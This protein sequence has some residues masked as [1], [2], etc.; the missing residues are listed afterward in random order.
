MK[1]T[2]TLI[3]TLA[4]SPLIFAADFTAVYQLAKEN[5]AAFAE[6]RAKFEAAQEKIPQGRAGLLPTISLSGN[7]TYNR[8]E[9]DNRTR[10]TQNDWSFNSNGLTLSLTQP[11]FRWQ[12]WVGYDQSKLVVAQAEAGLA[13]ARQDLILRTAQAYFDVLQSDENYAAAQAYQSAVAGQ[14]DIAKK[15]FEIGTGIQTDVHD[16]QTRYE[17]ASSQVIAAETEREVKRRALETIVGSLPPS[18]AG[19]RKGVELQPPQPAELAKWVESAEQNNLSVQQQRLAVEIASREVERQRAGHYPTLD[20]VA[21]AGH[22]STLSSGDRQITDASRIG[23]QLNVPIF[24]GGE[25]S[26][27]T[28]EAD[29]NRRA[30]ISAQETARRGAVLQARQSYLGVVNGLAQVKT[31]QA[32]NVAAQKAMTSNKDAFDV[33]VR[34]GIDVLNAQNQ[35]YVTRRDLTRTAVEMLI[36]QLRL[37]AAVGTLGEEDVQAV[38]GLLEK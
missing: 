4:L 25:V 16:A 27:K 18:L 6:A 21:S 37:K 15:A 19:V 2:L 12:N 3:S 35:V 34:L 8:E 17:I 29:A 32:A 31:L 23:L 28:A 38:N 7:T 14:L 9:I 11:L 10:R 26:S 30:A 5:D 20:L 24:Q 33:G 13:N 22:T 1:R 36:A